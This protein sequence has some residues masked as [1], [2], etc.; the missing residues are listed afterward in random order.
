MN[1]VYKCFLATWLL[2]IASLLLRSG[3]S[4]YYFYEKVMNFSIF[5]LMIFIY[6]YYLTSF[7][8]FSKQKDPPITKRFNILLSL[9][10][11][12]AVLWAIIYYLLNFLDW[13]FTKKI[14]NLFAIIFLISLGI[15]TFYSDLKTILKRRR[16]R[17]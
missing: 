15:I 6:M 5:V 1:K 7:V 2:V 4:E 12:V 16:D 3:W 17:A 14:V 13:S 10:M 9:V 8:S 11:I